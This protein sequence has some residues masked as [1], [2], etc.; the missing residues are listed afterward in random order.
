MDSLLKQEVFGLFWRSSKN[1]IT[2]I[3][4]IQHAQTLSPGPVLPDLIGG[5]E[6]V[7]HQK[8]YTLAMA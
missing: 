1:I 3:R 7:G 8:S 6:S 5:G 4:L 2:V